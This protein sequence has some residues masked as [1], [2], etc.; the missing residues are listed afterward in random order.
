MT[1]PKTVTSTPLNRLKSKVSVGNQSPANPT[2]IQMTQAQ[3]S[4]GSEN[5]GKHCFSRYFN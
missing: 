1:Q 3:A 2:V 5:F 4:A